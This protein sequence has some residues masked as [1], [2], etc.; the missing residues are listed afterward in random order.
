M[1]LALFLEH[2]A[3]FF[4]IFILIYSGVKQKPVTDFRTGSTPPTSKVAPQR[5]NSMRSVR[6]DTGRSK[7]R[8]PIASATPPKARPVK[9]AS[10]S[11]AQRAKHS[12]EERIGKF[13][14]SLAARG[15]SLDDPTKRKSGSSQNTDSDKDSMR[16]ARNSRSSSLSSEVSIKSS[17]TTSRSK[18]L[19]SSSAA[20]KRTAK[21]GLTAK[22]QLQQSCGVK[23]PPGNKKLFPRNPIQNL[24][25]FYE[26]ST[27]K[28]TEDTAEDKGE[29]IPV[30]LEDKVM[31][32]C[33]LYLTMYTQ[34]SYVLKG[35]EDWRKNKN[36]LRQIFAILFFLRMLSLR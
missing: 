16:S 4:V 30:V 1:F 24:I 13:R 9:V 6:S 2:V 28:V 34:I 18:A 15:H 27:D 3:R 19:A 29:R 20:V 23:P 17:S 32:D 25:R 5:S 35:L 10:E 7:D 22:K 26:A 21:A 31:N 8:L 12:S 33:L 36:F 14:K 11:L